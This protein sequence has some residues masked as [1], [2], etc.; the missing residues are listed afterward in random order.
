MLVGRTDG[1][2]V[3]AGHKSLGGFK[4]EEEEED[5]VEAEGDMAA[6]YNQSLGRP[7]ATASAVYERPVL[8]SLV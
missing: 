1:I 2:N 4:K 5:A 6:L 8:V 3:K 7:S